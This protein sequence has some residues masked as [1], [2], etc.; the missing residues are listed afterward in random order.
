MY[1]YTHTY[2]ITVLWIL[3][4]FTK[5]SAQLSRSVVSDSL[6]LHGTAHQASLSITISQSLLNLLSIESVMPSNRLVLCH[7]PLLLLEDTRV[8]S[9]L[10]YKWSRSVVSNS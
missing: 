4:I 2:I 9:W 8:H 1:I 7:P 10:D 3:K 6:C 5:I